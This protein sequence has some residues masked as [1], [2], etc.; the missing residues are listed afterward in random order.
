MSSQPP[1][2]SAGGHDRRP[3]RVEARSAPLDAFDR[4]GERPLA[5][6]VDA[7]HGELGAVAELPREHHALAVGSD[8][9]IVGPRAAREPPHRPARDRHDAQVAVDG[10]RVVHLQ[11]AVHQLPAVRSPREPRASVPERDPPVP[12]AV[13][14]HQPDLRV[15]RERL[16]RVGDL[17]PVGAE[18]GRA[19]TDPPRREGARLRQARAPAR[20]GLAFEAGRGRVRPRLPLRVQPGARHLV[21]RPAVEPGR[22]LDGV[23]PCQP[24][25]RLRAGERAQPA[26]EG[27]A[28]EVRRPVRPAR[29]R[30]RRSPGP[31]WGSARRPSP[32][33]AP[34]ASRRC[35][36]GRRP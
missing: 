7:D 35:G 32:S 17:P 11:L 15:A 1:G 19:L 16:A 22:E 4:P 26:Q 9:G 5:L 13:H 23:L 34:S 21:E 8:V 6:A 28:E 36:R 25:Q 14:A 30:A 18:T 33:A 10:E 29:R 20:L 31:P 3:A 27:L 2:S 24:R 12:R